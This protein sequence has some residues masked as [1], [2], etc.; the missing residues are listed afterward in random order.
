MRVGK[1]RREPG[2]PAA[3]HRAGCA[4]L[5]RTAPRAGSPRWQAAA[6]K[7]LSVCYLPCRVMA[8]A[9]GRGG[10]RAHGMPSRALPPSRTSE[11]ARQWDRT[12]EHAKP[13]TAP[14][15]RRRDGDIAPYRQA[16]REVRT[17][18]GTGGEMQSRMRGCA[19]RGADAKPRTAPMARRRDEDIAPYRQAARGGERQRGARRRA[20]DA[21]PRTAPMG[22]SRPTAKPHERGTRVAGARR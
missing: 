5:P 11:G 15:A 18:T 9:H 13:R 22:T 3:D 6:C 16:A 7:T 19:A 14:M 4:A 10:V 21:K 20:R 17:A 8:R 12:T 1:W 2:G